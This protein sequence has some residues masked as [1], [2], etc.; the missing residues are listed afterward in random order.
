VNEGFGVD[1]LDT[2]D[3]LIGQQKDGLQG[4]FAV[5]EVEEILETGTKKVEHHGI[6]VTLSAEPANEGN[7]DT[8]GKGLVDTSLILELRVL[9]LDGL[10]LDGNLLAGNDVC[11][12]VD[13]AEGSRTNFAAD[14]VLVTDAE[15]LCF[16]SACL[17]SKF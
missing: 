9:G 4:E 14:A 15:I 6:V 16:M 2:G 10:K 13:I 1:V 17:F 12:Q 3:E 11:P 8:A 7:A 5:A